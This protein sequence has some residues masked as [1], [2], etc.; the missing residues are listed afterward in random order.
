MEVAS[1]C[2]IFAKEDSTMNALEIRHQLYVNEWANEVRAFQESGMMLKDWCRENNIAVSTFSMHRRAVRQ[3]ACKSVEEATG[4]ALPQLL[5]STAIAEAPCGAPT[6]N[7]A[8]VHLKPDTGT[9]GANGLHIQYRD[10]QID[11]GVQ[12]SVEQLR[13]LFEV[14]FRAE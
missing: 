13:V 4:E 6:I 5:R 1:D 11:I 9:P 2:R 12:A 10:A 14:M 8:Q 7:L 3:A